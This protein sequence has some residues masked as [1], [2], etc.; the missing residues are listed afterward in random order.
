MSLNMLE[1]YEILR[2]YPREEGPLL[3]EEFRCFVC[4]CIH[5]KMESDDMIMFRSIMEGTYSGQGPAV[6]TCDDCIII[7]QQMIERCGALFD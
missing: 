1:I 6:P 3:P 4:G 7:C 5:D 2:D